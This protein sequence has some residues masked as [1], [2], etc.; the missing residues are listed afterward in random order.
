MPRSWAPLIECHD[1]PEDAD[2]NKVLTGDLSSLVGPGIPTYLI[3]LPLEGWNS[4]RLSTSAGKKRN[5]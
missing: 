5:L 4:S 1:A 2:V 3:E